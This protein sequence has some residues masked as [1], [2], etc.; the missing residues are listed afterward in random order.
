[1]KFRDVTRFLRITGRKKRETLGIS[2]ED[3]H[4]EDNA[5]KVVSV[6]RDEKKVC[7]QKAEER[8]CFQKAE[9]KASLRKESERVTF[10]IID[11]AI[12]TA[13]DVDEVIEAMHDV[14]LN[15]FTKKK[16]TS[17][18]R[19]RKLRDDMYN[20]D[21]IP[22]SAAKMMEMEKEPEIGVESKI[23]INQRIFKPHE[24]MKKEIKSSHKS[25]YSVL[26]ICT[27]GENTYI[28]KSSPIYLYPEEYGI[29]M[30][31]ARDFTNTQLETNIF[32]NHF[33]YVRDM[34]MLDTIN[35]DE[36]PESFHDQFKY[37]PRAI[38]RLEQ[39]VPLKSAIKRSA[40]I[41]SRHLIEGE[42]PE[43]DEVICLDEDEF[44]RNCEVLEDGGIKL[45]FFRYD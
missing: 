6:K 20:E 16:G 18:K 36:I 1:M 4:V 37:Y 45:D 33:Y 30:S 41:L 34:D 21:N 12:E 43:D 7:L 19:L 42:D 39:D 38:I 35:E 14:E 40:S 3:L 23:L 25:K 17:R 2:T 8:V 29:T 9:E 10:N 24:K 11:D 22:E 13:D 5:I 26:K 32:Y 28:I 31:L 27:F 44:H 15:S